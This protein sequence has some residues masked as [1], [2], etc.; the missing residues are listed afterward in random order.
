MST[1]FKYFLA[2]F[3][4]AIPAFLGGWYMNKIEAAP[5]A[6][7]RGTYDDG[8]QAGLGFAKKKLEAIGL[9]RPAAM[10]VNSLQATV[11]AVDGQNVTVEYQAS[12][13]DL[14][15]EGMVTKVLTL[16]V[17]GVIEEHLPKSAEA[18]EKEMSY[19]DKAFKD[20]MTSMTKDPASAGEPPKGPES[21]TVQAL[22]VADLKMGDWLD[23]QSEADVRSGGTLAARKIVVV[24]RVAQ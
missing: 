20:Y 11:K 4:T 2:I 12:D 8:Y 16:A 15:A 6:V 14:L 7:P 24:S 13:L 17:G 10:P 5:D 18:M 23:I 19:Y 1:P 9:V 22:T 21:F 3:L